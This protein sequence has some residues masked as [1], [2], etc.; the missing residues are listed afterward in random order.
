MSTERKPWTFPFTDNEWITLFAAV[1]S[2]FV[3]GACVLVAY[4]FFSSAFGIDVDF[5]SLV[6]VVIVLAL[7]VVFSRRRKR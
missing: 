2:A 5:V 7:Y 3:L 1:F 6:P 4:Q